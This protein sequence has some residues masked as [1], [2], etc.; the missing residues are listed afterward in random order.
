MKT[1]K[2]LEKYEEKMPKKV[3]EEIEEVLKNLDEDISKE[4]AKE[5]IE[6]IYQ[7]YKDSTVDP[8]ECVGLVSAESIGEPGTQMTLNT[9]HFAGV[10]EMNIT[11]GLPRLIEILDARKTL[12]NR[13]MDVYLEEEYRNSED[14]KRIA[15]EIKETSF[16]EFI[17]E[18]SIN[19]MDSEMEIKLDKEKV[20]SLGFTFKKLFKKISGKLKKSDVEKKEKNILLITPDEEKVDDPLKR[21]YK[22]KEKIK[23]YYISGVKK[24]D[25]VLPVKKDGEFMVITSGTNLKQV[26]KVEGVDKTRTISNDLYEIE[27]VFGIEAA[28]KHVIEETIKVLDTQGIN[29]DLRHLMLVADTMCRSGTLQGISRYGIVKNKPSVFARASFE[30]PIKHLFNAG[31]KMEKDDL[32]SVIENVMIN[33]PIPVGTGLPGLVT[34]VTEKG[35]EIDKKNL[36]KTKKSKNKDSK[37]KKDSS[38]K[39]KKKKKSKKSKKKKKS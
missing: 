25:Q 38:K 9:F 35:E 23:G 10:S 2:M 16:G 20:E 7:E 5:L 24:V 11:T 32:R 19:V 33:Q 4:R 13:R 30:T 21:I 14:A 26:L 17:S 39:D 18:I 8:G 28:R 3:I 12:K 6:K 1:K 29:I 34:K 36:G 15:E 31:I 37:S 27:E 22:L